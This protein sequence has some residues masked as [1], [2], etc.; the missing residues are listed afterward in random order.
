MRYIKEFANATALQAAVDNGEL[1]RPYLCYLQD[2][3]KIAWDSEQPGPTPHDYSKDY[4][5][6][7]ITKSGNIIW[8]GSASKTIMYS[9]DSGSTWTSISP[10]NTFSVSKDEVVFVKGNNSTYYDSFIKYNYFGGTATTAQFSVEG[11]ILSMIYGDSF[12]GQTTISSENT[13]RRLFY[14]CTGLTSA[15]NLIFPNNITYMCYEGMFQDCTSL[16]IAPTI[17]KLG[18]GCCARLFQNC[19]SLNYIKCL[20]T[21]YD[22]NDVNDWV[23][24]VSPTGTFVKKLGVNWPSGTSGIPNNWTVIEE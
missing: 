17:T 21:S 1:G 2:Q 20:A 15:E 22:V 6:F 24:G 5:T 23:T 10:K 19:T 14:K 12:S 7:R 3:G 11:N 4:L 16:T 8:N 13:F 9:K 18:S